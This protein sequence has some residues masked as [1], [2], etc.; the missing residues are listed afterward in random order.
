MLC[1]GNTANSC[2]VIAAFRDEP[3]AEPIHRVI[4]ATQRGDVELVT[5]AMLLLQARG[6]A[7]DFDEAVEL[8]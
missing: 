4:E 7:P 5:S 6:P 2:C 8:R 3:G 1:L